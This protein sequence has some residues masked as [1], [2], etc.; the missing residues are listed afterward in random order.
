M[1]KIWQIYLMDAKNIQSLDLHSFITT[2]VVN[3]SSMFA[4]CNKLEVLNLSSFN[5]RNLKDMRLC[6]IHVKV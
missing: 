5:T 4:Y 2:K 3:M 1:Y 6:L